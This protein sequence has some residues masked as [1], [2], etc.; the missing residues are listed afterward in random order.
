[1]PAMKASPAATIDEFLAGLPADQRDALEILRRQIRALAP[2]A[3]EVIAYGI[4][5]YRLHGRYLLGFGAAKNH[6]S[7][8]C[9]TRLRGYQAELEGYGT[10]TGTIH[11]TPNKPIPPAVIEGIVKARVADY[12]QRERR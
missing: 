12:E 2:E 10:R 6:C 8:Y 4:P 1:M 3:V 11:F 9:G 5:G 7:F